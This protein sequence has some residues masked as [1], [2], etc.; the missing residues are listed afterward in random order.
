[1]GLKEAGGVT[2]VFSSLLFTIMAC[3]SLC[4]TLLLIF[5]EHQYVLLYLSL[6]PGACWENILPLSIISGRE[7]KDECES[8]NEKKST[9]KLLT[10]EKEGNDLTFSLGTSLS[11]PLDGST[12]CW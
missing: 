4:C 10:K 3:V 6:S 7:K 9:I 2:F 1:M 8:E 11:Q 5:C 12:D